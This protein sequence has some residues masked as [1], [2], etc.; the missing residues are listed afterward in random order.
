M[1]AAVYFNS[2]SCQPEYANKSVE[3]LRWEDYQVGGQLLLLL[4]AYPRRLRGK[5]NFP[6]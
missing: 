4:Q 6:T 1:P 2:I 3:E 5:E